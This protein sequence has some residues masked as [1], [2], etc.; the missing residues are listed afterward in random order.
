MTRLPTI[1]RTLID[2]DGIVARVSSRILPAQPGL[3]GNPAKASAHERTLARSPAMSRWGHTEYSPE[4]P[5]PVHVPLDMIDW[6]CA[7]FNQLAGESWR[8]E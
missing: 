7:T 6:A 8:N 1:H 4:N 5:R 2:D 3:K